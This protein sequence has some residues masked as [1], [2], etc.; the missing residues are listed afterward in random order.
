MI[1]NKIIKY[2]TFSDFALF[3]GM[4][5]I[6]PVFPVFI[7]DNIQGGSLEVVGF[8]TGIHV[9]FRAIL[10]LPI[11]RY[12]DKKRGDLDE[13]YS[14]LI[15]TVLLAISPLFYLVI[16]TVYQLYTVEIIYAVGYAMANPAWL[17]LFTR[18]A[19]KEKEGSQWAIYSFVTGVGMA[20][21]SS[22][23]GLV[24]ERFGFHAIFWLVFVIT[25]VGTSVLLCIYEPLKKK[26]E[27]HQIKQKEAF[28]IKESSEML[29]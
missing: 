25:V 4:S 23:S 26:H 27:H 13:Y 21:A 2:L 8:A 5:L 20:G 14:L 1:L 10:A 3:S 19:E 24:A 16:N 6:A 15:G 22:L 9:F 28:E 7:I 18:H 29:K 11:A 17:S 12:L